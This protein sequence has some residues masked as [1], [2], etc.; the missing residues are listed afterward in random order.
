MLLALD[1]AAKPT[2]TRTPSLQEHLSAL[3]QGLS[4]PPLGTEVPLR[5][6]EGSLGQS[7]DEKRSWENAFPSLPAVSASHRLQGGRVA[8]APACEEGNDSVSLPPTPGDTPAVPP[9]PCSPAPAPPGTR[10]GLQ[11]GA[12]APPH[13]P[14]AARLPRSHWPALTPAPPRYRSPIGHHHRRGPAPARPLRGHLS[15]WRKI[16]K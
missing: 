8:A 4:E 16:N 11:A 12:G 14:G 15:L 3:L 5:P 1:L 7:R 10:R 9:A 6:G 13:W 2:P